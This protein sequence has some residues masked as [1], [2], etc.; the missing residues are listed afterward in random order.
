MNCSNSGSAPI[1]RDRLVDLIV[2]EYRSLVVRRLGITAE[3]R[4]LEWTDDAA[5]AEEPTA[6]SA[7][8]GRCPVIGECLAAALATDDHAEWRGGLNRATRVELW[9]GMDATYREVRDL[10]LLRLDVDR[11]SNGRRPPTRLHSIDGARP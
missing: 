6:T 3:W 4:V 1:D 2:F 7:T 5:C 11:L 9:T 8:C 10:E